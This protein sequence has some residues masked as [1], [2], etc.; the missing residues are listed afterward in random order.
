MRAGVRELFIAA[1][2]AAAGAIIAVAALPLQGQ[3]IAVHGTRRPAGPD[4]GAVT[5]PRR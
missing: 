3:A 2:A 5:R 1:M 4:L